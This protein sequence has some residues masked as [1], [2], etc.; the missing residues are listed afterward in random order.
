M[1]RKGE[2]LV[3]EERLNLETTGDIYHP[4]LLIFNAALGLGLVQQ[5]F[6]FND[7]RDDTFEDLSEYSLTTRPK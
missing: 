5:K 1:E 7:D 4:N 6:R 2:T 3:F